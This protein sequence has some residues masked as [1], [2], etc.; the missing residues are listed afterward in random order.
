MDVVRR[1]SRVQAKHLP[2]TP[3][4]GVV[5]SRKH[6]NT[7]STI[8]DQTVQYTLDRQKAVKKKLDAANRSFSVTPEIS[9]G[10]LVLVFSAAA[11]ETFK[12]V[13]FGVLNNLQYSLDITSTKDQSGAVIYDS[14]AVKAKSVK[15][16]VLNFY[17]S[18]SKVLLNGKQNYMIDFIQTTLQE[19]MG[20]LDQSEDF[21]S[22][23][24]TIKHYCKHYL[25]TLDS[26]NDHASN[27]CNNSSDIKSVQHID[28]ESVT[29]ANI[30]PVC[31]VPCEFSS[32]AIGCD[33]CD[34]WLHYS[35]EHLSPKDIRYYESDHSAQYVC[36]SCMS[37]QA[38]VA[39]D[40][41]GSNVPN[42]LV[43]NLENPILNI[44]DKP[45]ACEN[46]ERSKF[47]VMEQTIPKMP[48][49]NTADA[50]QS[51]I[52]VV[53][54]RVEIQPKKPSV[55]KQRSIVSTNLGDIHDIRVVPNEPN[56]PH[57]PDAHSEIGK[58]TNNPGDTG[59]RYFYEQEIAHLKDCLCKKEKLLR[60]K[61]S[62]IYKL[63]TDISSL[64][65]ELTTSRSY[66]ITLESDKLDLEHSLRIHKQKLANEL[67]HNEDYPSVKNS[68][69]HNVQSHCHH[70]A[71]QDSIKV[72]VLE[73][74]IK[75]LEFDIIKQDNK[76]A[77]VQDKVNEMHIHHIYN[78]HNPEKQR[79]RRKRNGNNNNNRHRTHKQANNMPSDITENVENSSLHNFCND[80]YNDFCT[81]ARRDESVVIINDPLENEMDN[82][83]MQ[84]PEKATSGSI[85]STFLDMRNRPRGRKKS[86]QNITLSP[87]VP[88]CANTQPNR[89]MINQ[90]RKVCQSYPSTPCMHPSDWEEISLGQVRTC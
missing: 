53:K 81:P 18:S 56:I 52:N 13:T 29:P 85:D 4:K 1:S 47:K 51:P 35:C 84:T 33:T 73:Q 10:N 57:V 40:S 69:K 21:T 62:T 26:S 66:I 27:K 45:S 55:S 16:Y 58:S 60:A 70:S 78:K 71:E 68:Q 63:Q 22:I 28:N 83:L 6:K 24:N 32:K 59:K 74:R 25:E 64:Q 87:K 9:P 7:K 77:N 36:R 37:L 80:N 82:Y 23:N 88:I 31:N 48:I 41:E 39:N 11:Y 46:L 86:V 43:A 50:N 30:C 17:H 34:K 5:K 2:F 67:S 76:M 61:D 72:W 8:R 44:S 14:V 89:E 12:N 15:L 90:Q 42:H 54:Q 75:T 20:V 49:S 65:K 38:S 19:I 79:G 3:G